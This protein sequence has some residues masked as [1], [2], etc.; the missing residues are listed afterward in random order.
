MSTAGSCPP[1]TTQMVRVTKIYILDRGLFCIVKANR[2]TRAQAKVRVGGSQIIYLRYMLDHPGCTMK[3]LK[4]CHDLSLGATRSSVG[5]LVHRKLA[6]RDSSGRSYRYYVSYAT[7]RRCR[8]AV[9]RNTGNPLPSWE[10]PD[11]RIT[12]PL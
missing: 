8:R 11:R 3:E 1:F 4:A 12:E 10:P 6:K 9:A 7:Y 2:A 5:G